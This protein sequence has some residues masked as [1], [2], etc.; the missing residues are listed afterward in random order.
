MC[1]VF[2]VRSEEREVARLA[3]FALFALQHRGQES[4]GIAVSERRE[5]KS[6]DYADLIRVTLVKG[7]D[8][9]R[10]VGTTLG[11]LHRPEVTRPRCR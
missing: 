11:Q 9:V 2:G 5:T 3:Y 6:R 10:V 7:D 4:A 8:T 1:G